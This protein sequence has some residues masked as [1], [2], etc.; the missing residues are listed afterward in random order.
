MKKKFKRF[1]TVFL[2]L[3][4]ILP[5]QEFKVFAE[6]VSANE[7]IEEDSNS[8][9]D[10]N[11]IEPNTVSGEDMGEE[12]FP[13]TDVTRKEFSHASVNEERMPSAPVHHCEPD[14]TDF[15]YIYFGSYPQSE[16]T[17]STIIAAIENAISTSGTESNADVGIDVLVDG[18]KYR[19]ISR[20]DT[21]NSGYFFGDNNY[22]YFKWEKIKWKVLQN[23]G[24]T[25]FVAS[26]KA[27][28]CKN[29]HNK[30]EEITWEGSSIRRWLN[31]SFYDT[32]F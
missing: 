30:E 22:R 9:Q 7:V 3:T 8:E 29:Y 25:L 16:V 12:T 11:P 17:D 20:S 4:M 32:A 26:D 15:R 5:I 18:I 27:L 13:E 1:I 14:H 24:N 6:T 19:R 23:D 2:V 28:D 21:N 10:T 31:D